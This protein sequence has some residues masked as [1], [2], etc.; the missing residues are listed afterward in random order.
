MRKTTSIAVG[1]EIE[2]KYPIFYLFPSFAVLLLSH[3]STSVAKS[4]STLESI[5]L[6]SW[7]PKN[8]NRARI[9]LLLIFLFNHSADSFRIRA[10]L[11]MCMGQAVS[12]SGK[13]LDREYRPSLSVMSMLRWFLGGCA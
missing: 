1:I 4:E 3:L 12:K 2:R 10:V 6:L 11:E 7:M 13:T 8:G 5:W 9:N